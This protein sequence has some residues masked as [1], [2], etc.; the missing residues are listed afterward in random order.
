MRPLIFVLRLF[1]V[2][3]KRRTWLIHHNFNSKWN[4]CGLKM[5]ESGVTDFW[6]YTAVCAALQNKSMIVVLSAQLPLLAGSR[7]TSGWSFMRG[8]FLTPGFSLI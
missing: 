8:T 1:F 5:G 2:V 4:H 6:R 3:M 7:T